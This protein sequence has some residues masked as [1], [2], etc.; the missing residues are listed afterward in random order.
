MSVR[1]TKRSTMRSDDQQ[2]STSAAGMSKRR[3][4][5]PQQD[6]LWQLRPVSDLKMSSIYNRSASE[7]P[8]ELFRLV[9]VYQNHLYI[10]II[11]ININVFIL[12]YDY[13]IYTFFSILLIFDKF[14]CILIYNSHTFSVIYIE[15]K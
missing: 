2:P 6:A 11:Y 15:R 5:E 13:K 9:R 10:Y 4:T 8:A 7:A 3:R 1:G 12:H 14:H